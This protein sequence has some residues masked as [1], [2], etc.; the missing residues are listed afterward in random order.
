MEKTVDKRGTYQSVHAA[1][2]EL[3]VSVRTVYALC[4][5]R[6]FPAVRISPRRIIIP[7]DGL[8]RWMRDNA[9]REI[10]VP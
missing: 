10:E 5:R 7:V 6:D 1:A 4:R 8:A 9:G 2:A 3:G